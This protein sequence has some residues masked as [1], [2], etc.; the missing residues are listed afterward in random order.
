MTKTRNKQTVLPKLASAE[1]IIARIKFYMSINKIPS[2]TELGKRIGMAQANIC[3]KMRIANFSL[4]EAID[5]SACLNVE[6]EK[7]F[8][9]NPHDEL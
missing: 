6:L 2:S 3:K 1:T 5:I 9:E 8:F 7:I 4:E